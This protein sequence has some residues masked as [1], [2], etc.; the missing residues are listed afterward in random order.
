MQQCIDNISA[1]VSV[2]LG[3]NINFDT[4]VKSKI[5]E[6]NFFDHDIYKSWVDVFLTYGGQPFCYDP[7]YNMR[8]VTHPSY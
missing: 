8:N 5:A 3:D 1:E 4:C 7:Y 2:S 6:L